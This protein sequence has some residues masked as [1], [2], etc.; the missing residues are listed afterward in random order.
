MLTYGTMRKRACFF[1][2]NYAH[3]P[4]G[5][6]QDFERGTLRR[7][8]RVVPVHATHRGSIHP[9]PSSEL[10]APW[11]VLLGLLLSLWAIEDDRAERRA[12]GIPERFR[13]GL[14]ASTTWQ[15]TS[16]YMSLGGDWT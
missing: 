1:I 14:H 9:F 2:G 6:S 10:C 13:G 11:E 7:V 12:A 4:E 8:R 3:L 5:F 15:N 16:R